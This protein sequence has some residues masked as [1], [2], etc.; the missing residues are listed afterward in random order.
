LPKMPQWNDL[1]LT[2]AP[3]RAQNAEH[4]QKSP[5]PRVAMVPRAAK[6]ITAALITVTKNNQGEDNT[7]AYCLAALAGNP[8]GSARLIRL[9]PDNGHFWSD[10]SLPQECRDMHL[11][12]RTAL[13]GEPQW[14]FQPIVVGFEAGTL[15]D[16]VT[17]PHRMDDVV[18]RKLEY[19]G[20]VEEP[21]RLYEQL[22]RIACDDILAVWP[23]RAWATPK[24]LIPNSEV[25]S[26]AIFNGEIKWVHWREGAAPHVDIVVDGKP[27]DRLPYAAHR[28]HD[29][30]GYAM[31]QWMQEQRSC[32]L[33]LGLSRTFFKGGNAPPQCPILLL[34]I[35]PCC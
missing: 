31:L 23:E 5:G 34:R 8:D 4:I 21:Q 32:V 28:L 30:R 25:P 33:L 26:L 10:D 24:S 9:V 6:Q 17:G 35:F 13:P 12:A 27:V 7:A 29:D 15:P 20:E 14:P 19:V 2:P 1:V 11:R 16:A 22:N 18:A 3:S